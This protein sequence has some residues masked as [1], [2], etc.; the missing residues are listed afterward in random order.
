MDRAIEEVDAEYAASPPSLRDAS[1]ETS[2]AASVSCAW[3][4]WAA[5]AAEPVPPAIRF[6]SSQLPALSTS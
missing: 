1:L 2:P 4:S 6:D 3:S 5:S